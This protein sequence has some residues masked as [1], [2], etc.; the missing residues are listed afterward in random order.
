VGCP[1][2]LTIYGESAFISS[3]HHKVGNHDLN[4]KVTYARHAAPDF[5]ESNIA[6]NKSSLCP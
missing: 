4:A 2:Y 6:K 5:R 3:M 1:V